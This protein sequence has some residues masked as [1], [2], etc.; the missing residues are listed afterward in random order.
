MIFNILMVTGVAVLSMALRSFRHPWPHRAG[1][2]GIFATSFLAGWLIGGHIWLGVLFVCSWLMLPWLEILTRVRALRLPIDR[3]LEPRTPPTR[4]TFPNFGELTSEVEQDG[5]EFVEDTGWEYGDQ[6]QFFRLFYSESRR[7]QAC[8]CLVEQ[9]DLAFFYI[10]LTSVDPDGLHLTT[11]NYPF[12]YG[13]KLSPKVK[14]HRVG[15]DVPFA[16]LLEAHVLFLKEQG[17][18]LEGCREQDPSAFAKQIEQEMREQILHNL[19][20][21][22]L[23]REGQEFI[24]YSVRGWFYLWLQFLRDLVRLS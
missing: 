2:V 6:R 18:T 13:L 19:D 17:L 7:A 3:S 4:N 8:I 14:F 1:T 22:L 16:S 9:N 23:V 11:W 15:G 12:S 5:F 10:S 21:G 20:R 24:R